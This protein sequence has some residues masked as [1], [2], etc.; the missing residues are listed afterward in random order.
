MGNICSNVSKKEL[1]FKPII[2]EDLCDDKE[3]EK[4]Q[5][6]PLIGNFNNIQEQEFTFTNPL[7]S[8]KLRSKCQVLSLKQNEF[9]YIFDGEILKMQNDQLLGRDQVEQ[10]SQKPEFFNNLEQIKYFQQ[11]EDY[12]S[13][14]QKYYKLDSYWKGEK[15]IEVGGFYSKNGLKQGLWKE[16]FKNFTIKTQVYF[17]GEYL[18]NKKIGKW[19]YIYK[20]K[21]IGGGFYNQFG[22]ASGKWIELSDRFCEESQILYQGYYNNG[23]KVSKWSILFRNEFEVQFKEVGGGLYDYRSQQTCIKIGEWMELNDEFNSSSQVF[24]CG[25][26]K[27]GIK[28]DRWD[29]YLNKDKNHQLIGGGQYKYFDKNSSI[30]DGKWVELCDGFWYQSQITCCGVYNNGKKVGK[31]NTYWRQG[32]SNK[33][34]YK[35]INQILYKPNFSGGGSYD[36]L[37]KGISMKIGKWIE[38]SDGFDSKAQ[39]IFVGVYNQG[40]KSGI[41]DIY[42]KQN[43]KNEYKYMQLVFII[44]IQSI[45]QWWWI[46]SQIQR[47]FSQGWQMD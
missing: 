29:I 6:M 39:V 3:S 47:E 11:I 7:S 10:F 9:M 16:T 40:K 31:W 37:A 18:N 8:R 13:N 1:K 45:N 43:G 34:M 21:K 2:D 38:L 12:G 15:L 17:L 42:W 26:Y 14:Q 36:D 27:N 23:Q 22:Q 19:R 32:E 35:F 33:K 44:V 4:L 41:W 30:K 20:N 24:Y 5:L 25:D 28:I 46:I